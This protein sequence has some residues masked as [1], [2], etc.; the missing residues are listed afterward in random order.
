MNEQKERLLIEDYII[1]ELQKG[2]W[3]YKE[4]EELN[5]ERY[6]EPLLVKDLKEAIRRINRNAELTE[7]DIQRVINEL[8]MKIPSMETAKKS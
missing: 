2:G 8:K 6:E 4:S 7:T 1:K 5:R 3:I